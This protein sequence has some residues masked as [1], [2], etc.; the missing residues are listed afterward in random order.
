MT[1]GEREQHRRGV[2][3]NDLADIRWL[4]FDLFLPLWMTNEHLTLACMITAGFS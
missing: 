2:G 3:K 1:H 4:D